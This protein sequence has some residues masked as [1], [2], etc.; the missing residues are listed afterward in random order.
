MKN[1]WKKIKESLI[2]LQMAFLSK[3]NDVG[4]Y[5]SLI[6]K[7]KAVGVEEKEI[8]V[9]LEKGGNYISEA[10]KAILFESKDDELYRL[11]EEIFEPVEA[12]E[13]KSSEFRSSQVKSGYK[14]TLFDDV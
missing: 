11:A 6:E 10:N 13:V 14:I 9:L 5:R 12:G 2:D 3:N 1:N 8:L 4:K 7:A